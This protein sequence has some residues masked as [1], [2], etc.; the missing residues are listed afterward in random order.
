MKKVIQS[1][2]RSIWL[3]I[4]FISLVFCA[5]FMDAARAAEITGFSTASNV[6]VSKKFN[7]T[8][9]FK[10]NQIQIG[11]STTFA[12][13]HGTLQIGDSFYLGTREA[14][15]R[16]VNYSNPDD[17]ATFSRATT[18]GFGY[19]ESVTYD[20]IHDRIYAFARTAST[21]YASMALL[22]I[23]PHNINDWQVVFSPGQSYGGSPAIVTDG[24]YVYL[25]L[26]TNPAYFFK[27]R[28]SDWTRVKTQIWTG[29]SSGHAATL[30]KYADR[31]ELFFTANGT[32]AIPGKFAKVNPVDLS[33][34]EIPNLVQKLTD[35]IYCRKISEAGSYCYVSTESLTDP[36]LMMVDTATM[37]KTDYLAPSSYGVF[38]D[39]VNL[40]NLNLNGGI[41][42]YPNFD[43]TS[44]KIYEFP[45]EIPN[46][47]FYTS[48]GKKF[49]TNWAANSYLKEYA[50]TADV[51][52]A[53]ALTLNWSSTPV[54]PSYDIYT[55]T[56]GVTYTFNQL[57]TSSSV[58]FSTLAP[59]TQYWFKVMATGTDPGYYSVRT[60]A[61]IPA[62][63]P[64]VNNIAFSSA[65]STSIPITWSG[66]GTEY[67]IKSDI[68]SSSTGWISGNS[69][70]F[71]GLT[72]GNSY[73]YQIKARNFDGVES[74]YT[75]I[76]A[77][78]CYT[79]ISSSVISNPVF[80][81]AAIGDGAREQTIEMNKSGSLGIIGNQGINY[82]SYINSNADFDVKPSSADQITN[83]HLI[84]NNLD[85]YYNTIQLEIQSMPQNYNLKVGDA[86]QIDL[87]NDK[88]NDLEIKF[89]NIW[90][91]RAELT[92]KSLWNASA[93]KAEN[94]I[95]ESA[96]KQEV[97]GRKVVKQD[98]IKQKYLFKRN[99]SQGM[100]GEDVK[101]LQKFLNANNFIIAK[102]GFG[103]PGNETNT[104]GPA[105]KS[106]LIKFQ[107]SIKIFPSSGYFGP[108]TR[109]KINQN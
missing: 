36:K 45:G 48:T 91:S 16:F 96:V 60:A 7:G 72:C 99:F 40:Y 24:T 58:S 90:I 13:A 37:T 21:S 92:I 42:R 30:V 43:L 19:L 12:W 50:E 6:T 64:V 93:G 86:V 81:P 5:V 59:D 100:V 22:S 2:K 14:P 83:H 101:E 54:V 33:Y 38:S 27:I 25:V 44:P 41:F 18:T 35:D 88:I 3:E 26:Y 51:A 66:N 4:L 46:E 74:D 97:A 47:F 70:T 55:S 94:I 76:N 65:E 71:N 10:T 28:I 31:T 102:N 78:T 39:G 68:S 23:N 8:A 53:N 29:S 63:L 73:H 17:L 61:F 57:A 104:F 82:L 56:D 85:L 49:F 62:S 107:A 103:S 77:R 80:L 98:M 84:I 1:F 75:D 9:I 32:G 67:Y 11:S 106:A 109:G 105:T 15:G 20:D 79:E 95:K 89:T 69:Y 34:V 108:I 87:D 52:S